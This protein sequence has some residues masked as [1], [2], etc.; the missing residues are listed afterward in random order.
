MAGHAGVHPGH[1]GRVRWW[2]VVLV[3]SG[4]CALATLLTPSLPDT[5]WLGV[6]KQSLNL[7]LELN[8]AV[9][10]S[11]MLLACAAYLAFTLART[12]GEDVIGWSGLAIVFAG[13]SLDELGSV[14]ERD[15]AWPFSPTVAVAGIIVAVSFFRLVRAGR[16]RAVG[17]IVVAF[18]LFGMAS[19]VLE[20]VNA[21]DSGRA[22]GAIML[23]EEGTE[24]IGSTLIL[25]ALVMTKTDPR[26]APA[27]PLLPHVS[28]R[29]SRVVFTA[30]LLIGLAVAV[31]YAPEDGRGDPGRWFAAVGFLLAAGT[32]DWERLGR[33]RVGI[34]AVLAFWASIDVTY[35]LYDVP[36]TERVL[37]EAALHWSGP[38]VWLL[39]WWFAHDRLRGAAWSV[40][41]LALPVVALATSLASDSPRL[42]H[43]IAVCAA[44]V[45]M[46][47]LSALR[48]DGD[49]PVAVESAAPRARPKSTE[50]A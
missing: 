6:F 33:G 24:L 4:I 8:V 45:W 30:V 35:H 5:E 3:G 49:P 20:L 10:W 19:E 34:A 7:G 50:P 31:G 18:V 44:I 38:V 26:T 2:V 25:L 9:W 13:L 15:A 48:M 32:L 23:L 36:G 17:L 41:A 14:H 43:T 46:A 29:L 21:G 1:D 39:L 47:G 37:P 11:S 28:D 42:H 12:V 16:I 22:E 40:A 27:R